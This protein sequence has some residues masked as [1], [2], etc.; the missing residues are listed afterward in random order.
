[1]EQTGEGKGSAPKPLMT[2]KSGRGKADGVLYSNRG[3]AAEARAEKKSQKNESSAATAKG[4]K[5]A[6]IP[7]FVAPQLCM[8]VDRPP[9]AEGW[10]HE[11]KFDGYRVQLRVEDG[12]AALRTGK[13]LD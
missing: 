5:V 1:M 12:D 8:P 10:C 3:D 11:I 6:A 13:G 7:D 4:R 2:P 9:N